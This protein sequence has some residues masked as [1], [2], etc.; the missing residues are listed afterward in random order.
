MAFCK[1]KNSRCGAAS[2]LGGRIACMSAG[3]TLARFPAPDQRMSRPTQALMLHRA[4]CR[5]LA[6]RWP[7]EPSSTA[8]S[9]SLRAPLRAGKVEGTAV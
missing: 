4:I 8:P 1:V 3:K 9:C 7:T 5:A 6:G 2:R